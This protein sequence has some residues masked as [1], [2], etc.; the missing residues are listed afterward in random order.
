LP[1][2]S[3]SLSAFFPFQLSNHRYCAAKSKYIRLVSY[4]FPHLLEYLNQIIFENDYNFN[5]STASL[6]KKEYFVE[7]WKVPYKFNMKTMFIRV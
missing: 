3:S 4:F 6:N 5:V 2:T 7:P 1:Q